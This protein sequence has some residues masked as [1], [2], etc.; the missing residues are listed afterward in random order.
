LIVA[1]VTAETSTESAQ[2][3]L[4]EQSSE[5]FVT[6]AWTITEFSSA[7][8]LKLRTKHLSLELR[9]V[10]MVAFH[11]LLRE[12]LAVVQVQTG[13]FH[14]AAGYVDQREL[15]L[16]SGDALHLAVTADLGATLCT[17]DNRLARIGAALSIPTILLN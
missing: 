1:A 17:L 3:W 8:A 11:E 6:N 10:A 13:H 2:A 14:A 5:D 12:N 16:R 15:G 9:A 7:L 4:L